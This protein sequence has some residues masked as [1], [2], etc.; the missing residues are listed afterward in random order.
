MTIT[1]KTEK[2]GTRI[3]VVG[4]TYAIKGQLKSAGCHWDGERKQWWIGAAKANQIESIVGRL[5][6]AKVEPSKS[7]LA[8]RPCT[9]KVEY[10]GR[11]YYVI[12]RS[13][14]TGKLWLTVL[15]CSIDF[16]AA[17]FACK[18][19][20]RYEAREQ[21]DGR[22]YS[23]RTE[24]VYQTVAKIRAFIERS[25]SNDAAK[26]NGTAE[27]KRCWECGRQFT[28][29]DARTNDGDWSDSYCGC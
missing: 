26:Q 29:H 18:W 7:E 6:G 14:K 16:W 5:D 3:Y 23:G 10:K 21:W 1:V 22:R 9:G 4:N 15:D 12:G 28:Q 19:V 27:T 11:S 2:V 25:K 24:T 8:D 17:E 13:E 20:K